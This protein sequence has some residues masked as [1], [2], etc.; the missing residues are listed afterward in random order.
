V[1]C[2]ESQPTFWRNISLSSLELKRKA[3]KKHHEV[4]SKMC[5]LLDHDDGSGMFPLT[6]TRVHGEDRNLQHIFTCLGLDVV[7]FSLSLKHI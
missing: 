1:Q 6:F 4:C 7:M 5:L 2:N 3:S